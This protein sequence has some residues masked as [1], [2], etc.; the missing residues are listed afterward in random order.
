[1]KI[2]N[3]LFYV[4]MM[5]FISSCSNEVR[6]GFVQSP[7]SWE[8]TPLLSIS[9][10]DGE[11]NWI[12]GTIDGQNIDF[13]FKYLSDLS[14]VKIKFECIE[15]WNIDGVS[16][17]NLG[18]GSAKIKFK[19]GEDIVIYN[20]TGRILQ[21][22]TSIKATVDNETVDAQFDGISNFIF[23]FANAENL[24]SVRLHDWNLSDFAEIISPT[25]G[26]LET[27]IDFAASGNVIDLVLKD[28]SSENTKIFKLKISEY[29]WNDVTESY[30]SV[31]PDGAT[32]YEH[33]RI[34]GIV[35]NHAFVVRIPAGKIN[36]KPYH[37]G[38]IIKA[39]GW[40]FADKS[41]EQ[42]IE[43]NP[44]SRMFIPALNGDTWKPQLHSICMYNNE[45][46]SSFRDLKEDG[47]TEIGGKT[48]VLS[49]LLWGNN[50]CYNCPPTL[51]IDSQKKA[52]ITYAQLNSDGKLYDFGDQPKNGKDLNGVISQ[53][54]LIND[55]I[56]SM[57]GYSI[58][59]NNGTVETDYQ[60]LANK[61][62][63][64][65]MFIGVS[66]LNASNLLF[67]NQDGP[68]G[69]T[70]VEFDKQ[71]SARVL[72][73]VNSNHDLII[74]VS[75]RYTGENSYKKND[76]NELGDP[77]KYPSVGVTMFEAAQILKDDFECTDAIAFDVMQRAYVAF[78]NNGIPNELTKTDGTT[79]GLGKT[80]KSYGYV[81]N[82]NCKTSSTFLTFE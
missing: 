25:I 40:Y 68:K 63:Y 81:E 29:T 44:Q 57:S 3:I 50:L 67:D 39:W 61:E 74:F 11:G 80:L 9:A 7:G 53:G 56:A 17:I 33:Q 52:Y 16:D 48:N 42:V 4:L 69:K 60:T 8:T 19:S 64:M 62:R 34:L 58:P 51:Y 54:T 47:K 36:M 75:E 12:E 30:I 70:A 18:N 73:G 41:L 79:Y 26:E 13:Q 10:E 38:G 72:M 22:I 82:E 20:V 23:L 31:L 1:M 65:S 66:G 59:L 77:E 45:I 71:R 6:D 49:S 14:S 37:S 21:W 32:I 2:F 76:A 43:A 46:I 24:S 5:L 35:N 27:G 78:N 15:N 55:V 28:K